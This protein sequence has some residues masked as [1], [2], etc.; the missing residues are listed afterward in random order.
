MKILVRRM[1]EA[2]TGRVARIYLK[3]FRGMKEYK[4]AKKW[5]TLRHRSHPVSQYFVAVMNGKVVGYMEWIEHGGFRKNS[6]IELEQIAIDPK[7]QGMKIG[8]ALVKES[9]AQVVAGIRKRGSGLKLVMV[10]TS[11]RHGA[12]K[13]YGKVLRAKQVAVI[14]DFFRSDEAVLIARK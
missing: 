10:K 6:V 7:Y 8:E 2:E 14:P 13:F 9:L 1:R 4:T 11:A 3:C 12:G 5:I